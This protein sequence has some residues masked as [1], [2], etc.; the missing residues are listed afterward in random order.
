MK[1][2]VILEKFLNIDYEIQNKTFTKT[3]FKD[4]DLER[5]FQH[6]I[7]LQNKN[8]LV[9]NLIVVLGY[10][11]TFLYILLAFYRIVFLISCLLCIF[12]TVISIFLSLHSEN[13]AVKHL[14]SH[15]QI[16]L[17]SFNLW[18][19]AIVVCLY[20][21]TPK[22]DNTEE[23]LRI[24]IYDFVSTNIFLVVKLEASLITSL[25][26]FCQN[27]VI[28]LFSN[29]YSTGNHY[30]F[31][32]AMTSFFVFV[33]FYSLRKEWDFRVREIF[34]QKNKFEKFFLYVQDYLL[35]LN[36]YN[37][38]IQNGANVFY[39]QKFS[40]LINGLEFS[41]FL[42]FDEKN[43]SRNFDSVE[44]KFIALIDIKKKI[45]EHDK[46]LKFT[47]NKLGIA[48]PNTR[49]SIEENKLLEFFDNLKFV[50]K[51]NKEK[52]IYMNNNNCNKNSGHKNSGISCISSKFIIKFFNDF[53]EHQILAFIFL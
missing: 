1:S 29:F 38:S 10:L 47:V 5:K 52:G 25:F 46:Q 41:N 40:K 35:G 43:S 48:N 50:E 37:L 2:E 8:S 53:F 20:Y 49:D 3:K 19:K 4:P 51:Y 13:A 30:F 23:L 6:I 21:N 15:F 42:L 39:N 17:S 14:H 32:E 11:A 31:L 36:G 22:N 18:F 24:I 7:F 45:S 27:F 16:F 28:I 9:Q 34:S 12:F 33:I 44:R 26:Y